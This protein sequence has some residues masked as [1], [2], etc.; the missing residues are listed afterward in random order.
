VP[1]QT[2]GEEKLLI[3]IFIAIIA[4]I[5]VLQLLLLLL[6]LLCGGHCFITLCVGV[7]AGEVRGW[8]RQ[9]SF[10]SKSSF[11][12]REVVEEGIDWHCHRHWSSY[13]CCRCC[14][15]RVGV[16]VSSPCA[17]VSLH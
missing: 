6:R 7:I 9:V 17:W 15:C 2:G 8:S 14:G 16:I 11:Q 5:V 10:E 13:C 4:F 1:F 12:T 3:D